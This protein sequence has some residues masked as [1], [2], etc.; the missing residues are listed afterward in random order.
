MTDHAHPDHAHPDQGSA[1]D[2]NPDVASDTAR[3]KAL[4]ESALVASARYWLDRLIDDE[5]GTHTTGR[6]AL[7]MQVDLRTVQRWRSGAL[8]PSATAIAHMRAIYLC[9]RAAPGASW[10]LWAD[11]DEGFARVVAELALVARE[12]AEHAALALRRTTGR[13]VVVEGVSGLAAK[14]WR[15]TR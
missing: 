11:C 9:R 13:T 8:R 4:R 6:L 2:P 1:H 7:E 3:R 10:R 5:D 12:P 14:R 15:V